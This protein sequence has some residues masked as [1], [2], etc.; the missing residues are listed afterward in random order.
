MQEGWGSVRQNNR[1]ALTFSPNTFNPS[2]DLGVLLELRWKSRLSTSVGFSYGIADI[3]YSATFPQPRKAVISP[4][5]QISF[6]VQLFRIPLLFGYRV[7]GKSEEYYIQPAYKGVRLELLAGPVLNNATT[8]TDS[9]FNMDNTFMAGDRITIK[10]TDCIVN[11]F[12]LSVMAGARLHYVKRGKER[13]ALTVYFNQGITT[14][15]ESNIN[16]T[17]NE[18]PYFTQMATRGTAVG[19]NLLYPIRLKRWR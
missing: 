6:G 3:S 17:L 16:Y 12:G 14:H 15:I 18:V 4:V 9:L 8:F 11:K 2:I 5:Q 10:Q 7:G 13:L 1:S 19:V